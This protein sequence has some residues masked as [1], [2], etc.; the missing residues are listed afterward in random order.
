MI[1][2]VFLIILISY[3]LG[4]MNSSIIISKLI[5]NKDIRTVGSKNAGFTNALRNLSKLSA[6][7]TFLL[8]FFKGVF[9]IYISKYIINNN[10]DYNYLLYISMFMCMIGHMYPC[11][12]KFKGG[13]GVLVTWGSTLLINWHIFIFTIIVFLIVLLMTRTVSIASIFA[14]LSF[15]AVT[16]FITHF[17]YSN[18][19]M[20]FCTLVTSIISFVIILK[21]KSNISRLI[22]GTENKIK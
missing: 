21:H 16:L 1:S 14:A 6:T 8:D 2:K 19:N 22:S 3:L 17:N 4:S 15:P 12:F 5:H 18:D 7:F 20:F 9:A 13:K 10:M 11:F